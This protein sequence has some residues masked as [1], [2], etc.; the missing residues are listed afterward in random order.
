MRRPV[1]MAAVMLAVAGG[2]VGAG[3]LAALAEAGRGAAAEK[4]VEPLADRAA[5]PAAPDAPADPDAMAPLA[6]LLAA[7]DRA[8]GLERELARLR[9]QVAA[10]RRACRTEEPPA[11]AQSPVPE[12]LAAA[13]PRSAIF[14]PAQPAVEPAPEP[15]PGPAVALPA[16]TPQRERA[17]EPVRVAVAEPAV[18]PPAVPMPVQPQPQ[19][20]VSYRPGQTLA[21]PEAAIQTGDLAFLEGCWISSP[22]ANPVNG[23]AATK[24]YCFDRNGNGQMN[25]RDRDGTTCTAPIQARWE[26]GRRLV[27]EEPRDGTCSN[28]G[29]WYREATNCSIGGDGQAQCNSYEFFRRFNYATRL[30]R[31]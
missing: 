22:F 7:A 27:M 28:F 26:P 9:W 10:Q 13:G 14:N 2:G 18:E 21:V 12:Q 4:A 6:R 30:T 25:F 31:S 16:A 5:V 8:D 11:A 20:P 3:W 24:S 19:P 23:N 1:L 17:P 15:A 29:P